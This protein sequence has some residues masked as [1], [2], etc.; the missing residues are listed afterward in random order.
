MTKQTR[1]IIAFA[2]IAPLVAGPIGCASI[3]PENKKAGLPIILCQPEDQHPTSMQD[4]TFKVKAKGSYL[5]YEWFF[6]QTNSLQQVPN[7]QGPQVVI[8]KTNVNREGFYWCLIDSSGPKGIMQTRTRSAALNV[9]SLALNAPEQGSLRPST[10]GSNACANPICGFVNFNN[11][12]AGYRPITG[13]MQGIMTLTSD[14]GGQN[15]IPTS[16]YEAQWRYGGGATQCGCFTN[17]SSSQ[18]T[19]TAPVIAAYAFTVYIKSGCPPSGT[20]YY[21]TFNFP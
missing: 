9:R 18:K 20:P 10:V 15:V 1:R 17:L 19:F 16:S 11:Y 5:S 3:C 14:S 13:H 6:E 4:A 8:S 7:G 12:G 21:L 2:A